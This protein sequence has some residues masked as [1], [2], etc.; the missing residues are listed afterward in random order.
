MQQFLF[1]HCFQGRSETCEDKASCSL[2]TSLFLRC[3]PLK[4]HEANGQGQEFYFRLRTGDRTGLK[5][6]GDK[7][8]VGKDK[9]TLSPPIPSPGPKTSTPCS[10]PNSF[11]ASALAL[12]LRRHNTENPTQIFCLH[13][14][15]SFH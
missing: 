10:S 6:R 5:E 1:P 3:L 9:G 11:I 12:Q 8:G 7:W 14:R 4:M 2:P 13:S 15:N